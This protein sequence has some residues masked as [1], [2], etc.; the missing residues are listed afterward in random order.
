MSIPFQIRD[1]SDGKE[2]NI[3]AL[4][5][6]LD[7]VLWEGEDRWKPIGMH[8]LIQPNQVSDQSELYRV[9]QKHVRCLNGYC[10][11]AMGAITPLLKFFTRKVSNLDFETQ[12]A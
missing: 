12:Y 2:R 9:A 7:T 10:G 6:S 5:C 4:I 3:R 11:A 1:W 8:E